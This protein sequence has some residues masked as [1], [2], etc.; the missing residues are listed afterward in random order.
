MMMPLI[1]QNKVTAPIC[2]LLQH[3]RWVPAARLTYG[4][5]L[6]NTVFMTYRI[7][8]L[9]HG[10][11]AQRFTIDLYFCAFLALSFLFSLITYIFVEAPFANL[12]NFFFRA[13][14]VSEALQKSSQFYRSQSA[15]AHLRDKRKPKSKRSASASSSDSASKYPKKALS[16]DN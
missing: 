8:N 6:C 16:T 3:K 2:N 7:F 4:V 12:L 10:E 5:F 13:K 11:W 1:L 14:S 9:Q 15:K